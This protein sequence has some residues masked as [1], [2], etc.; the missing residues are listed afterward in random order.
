MANLNRTSVISDTNFLEK[1]NI[2]SKIQ[3]IQELEIHSPY[4]A[5]SSTRSPE[6][7]WDKVRRVLDSI[8]PIYHHAALALF[9]NVI[10]LPYDLLKNA[11]EFLGFEIRTYYNLN[12]KEIPKYCWISEF[13]QEEIRNDFL[14]LNKIEGRKDWA[15]IISPGSLLE[16]LVWLLNNSSSHR[17]RE[18]IQEIISKQYWILLADASLSG[19]SLSSEIKKLITVREILEPLFTVLPR[20]VVCCQIITET[21]IEKIKNSL[22]KEE[23]SHIDIRSAMYF[24]RKFSLANDSCILFYDKRTLEKVREFC[25]WVEEKFAS[26]DPTLKDTRRVSG[27][28][29]A[30][31]F[32]ECAWTIV[33]YRNCPNDSAIPLWYESPETERDLFTPYYSG[34]FPYVKSRIVQRT[35]PDRGNLKILNNRRKDVI[36]AL[37]G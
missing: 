29:L 25:R 34:P 2:V 28:D 27:G 37:R 14:H 4:R 13:E 32:N 31:G 22:S 7:Y 18:D 35:S 10:Y 5:G 8:P 6:R 1:E 11:W 21:A 20:I 33:T 9:A 15:R 19:T 3:Y 17:I 24:D 26:K 36:K 30:F 12:N 16:K 23:F